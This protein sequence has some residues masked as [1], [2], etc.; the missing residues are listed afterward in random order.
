MAVRRCARARTAAIASGTA[1][2]TGGLSPIP[3]STALTR[4]QVDTHWVAAGQVSTLPQAPADAYGAAVFGLGPDVYWRLNEK[5][6]TTAADSGRNGNT[7]TYSGGVMT[8]PGT[9]CGAP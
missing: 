8:D 3:S 9:S 6:G 5:S 1:A 2:A 7:A 4:Q